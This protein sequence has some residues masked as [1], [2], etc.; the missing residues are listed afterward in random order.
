MEPLG[1]VTWRSSIGGIVLAI[2]L[3]IQLGRGAERWVPF[4]TMSRR[5]LASISGAAISGVVLNLA[6]FVAFGRI[7]VALALL[8][9]YT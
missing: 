6:M 1:F 4:H 5:T 3:G 7:T 9:F 2:Y 8:T